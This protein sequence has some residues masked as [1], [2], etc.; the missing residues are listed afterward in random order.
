MGVTY[1]QCLELLPLTAQGNSML[2]F[3]CALLSLGIDVDAQRL[4][5]EELADIEVPVVVLQ[6]PPPVVA[7]GDPVAMGHYFVVW[8]LDDQRIKLLDYPREP[9]VLARDN[10]LKHLQA[11]EARAMP[12]LLCSQRHEKQRGNI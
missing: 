12:T 11:A 1:E 7:S 9:V 10:W 6:L 4:G 3:K 8:P 5:P 2:E